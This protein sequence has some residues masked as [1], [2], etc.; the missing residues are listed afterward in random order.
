MN[1]RTIKQ[2]E[3]PICSQEKAELL[4]AELKQRPDCIDT[5]ENLCSVEAYFVVDATTCPKPKLPRGCRTVPMPRYV[6]GDHATLHWHLPPSR[7]R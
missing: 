2:Y 4:V 3:G 6:P 1:T 5:R 7:I